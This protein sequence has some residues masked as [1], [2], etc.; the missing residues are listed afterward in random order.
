MMKITEPSARA[1]WNSC[2][3]WDGLNLL[4]PVLIF[5]PHLLLDSA[6]DISVLPLFLSSERLHL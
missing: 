4:L 3:N 5:P 1:R 6:Q 2:L